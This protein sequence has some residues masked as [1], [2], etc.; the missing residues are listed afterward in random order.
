MIHDLGTSSTSNFIA[1]S[2][3]AATSC[4][5]SGESGVTCVGSCVSL[6]SVIF[7]ALSG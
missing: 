4:F 5:C 6:F 3:T 7:L 1:F 2:S